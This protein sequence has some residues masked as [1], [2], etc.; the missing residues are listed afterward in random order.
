MTRGRSIA[1]SPPGRADADG[2]SRRPE[3]ARAGDQV[4]QDKQH[5]RGILE[6]DRTRLLMHQP[7]TATLALQLE[8]V[9]V[10]DNRLATAATDGR[11]VYFD[12]RFLAALDEATRLFVL[13]HEVWHCA[14]G[15]IARR[16]DRE[17]RCWNLA[18][19]HEV[20]ALLRADGLPL[21]RDAVYFPSQEGCSAEAVYSWLNQQPPDTRSQDGQFDD[22]T[23]WETLSRDPDTANPGHDPEFLPSPVTPE[24]MREWSERVVG[25][26]Q[27]LRRRGSLPAGLQHWLDER[28]DPPLPWPLLMQRFVQRVS[29]GTRRWNPP[30]RRHLHIPLWLP[31]TRT[32]TLRVMVAV[33]TSGS[34]EPYWSDFMMQVR[35]LLKSF[36]QVEVTLVECD[37]RISRVR[38]LHL[39]DSAA[40]ARTGIR[41][42]GGTD[43]RP[44]FE[45][46]RRDPPS[47]LIYLTDGYGPAPESAPGF[48]V[49][50]VI[51]GADAPPVTWGERITLPSQQISR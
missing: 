38:K 39:E 28:L 51:A 6:A 31:G 21:P 46:A 2:A 48:P 45:L 44:P 16:V 41:G 34:T 15:H 10:R 7:F 1:G 14:A 50:W 36:D 3:P 8:L 42:G 18:V 19:D 24:L 47:C 17:A 30:S 29:G 20:N 26:A 13:A 40:I 12:M 32:D 43:L 25:A 11:R 35:A 9:P 22:H 37:A 5:W 49:L 4:L 27:Q 33:D 23:P